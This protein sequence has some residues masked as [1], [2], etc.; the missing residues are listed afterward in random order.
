MTSA[1]QHGVIQ[2][3]TTYARPCAVYNPGLVKFGTDGRF[4]DP[5]QPLIR[6]IKTEYTPIQEYGGYQL[7]TKRL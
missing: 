7:L 2:A 4:F 6:M 3:M 1:A 5:E